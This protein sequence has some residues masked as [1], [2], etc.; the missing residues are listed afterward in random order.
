MK[1]LAGAL[2][3][4]SLT[5]CILF[6]ESLKL[7]EGK[8]GEGKSGDSIYLSKSFGIRDQKFVTRRKFV[9]T[10]GR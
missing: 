1:A 9:T 2:F 6:S 5:K 4:F 3:F 7:C 10:K 8:S